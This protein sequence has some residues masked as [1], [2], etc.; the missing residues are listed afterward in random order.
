M[1]GRRPG[2]GMRFVR[3]T[4][5]MAGKESLHVIRDP[6]TLYL[7]LGMPVVLLVIFG[8]GVSFDMDDVPIAVVDQDRT[9][10][11]RELAEA[12]GAGGEFEV[13][14]MPR[15]G[16]EIDGLFRRR[17]A[18]AA[19]VLPAGMQA[20]WDRG[21][22]VRV[23]VLLDGS[24]GTSAANVMGTAVGA[25]Q[26]E[27][28]RRLAEQTGGGA[29]PLSARVR[30]LFN[31]A[32]KSAVFFVPGLIAYI[33]YIVGVLLT[34]L[35][36]AREAERGNLEQLFATPVGRFEV[37]LG[38][39]LPYL[40]IG[41]VQAL[42]VLAFGMWVFDMPLRGSV[43]VVAGGTLLFL[44]GALGQGLFISSIAGSQQVATQAGALSSL[45]PGI[46]LSGFVIPVE[47]MPWILQGISSIFPARYYVTM[48]RG[49][50][51]K[52]NGLDVL[53][54][55]FVALAVF[56]AVALLLAAA[57]FKRRLS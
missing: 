27:S 49:V 50:M 6:R 43:L 16:D 57:K 46:L 47:N 21:E 8:F 23:Q 55:Q 42:L 35:T 24:D 32:L 54:P 20:A 36:V 3:R 22:R 4:L 45:L 31:P 17:E 29:A 15:D 41:I 53:W 40:A 39:L 51:L 14:A 5:A 38:K 48:L 13:V 37:L 7:A 56:C 12:L 10:A 30:L 1:S 28:A 11:S 25:I 34:A 9:P 2:R 18:S 26:A 44:V 52:G 33:L 19:G